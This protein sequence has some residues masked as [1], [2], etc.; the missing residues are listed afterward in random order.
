MP[1]VDIVPDG[2]MRKFR[3]ACD[4]L[5]EGFVRDEQLSE[6]IGKALR[7]TLKKE[8]N[9]PIELLL[10]TLKSAFDEVDGEKAI[11]A[12]GLRQLIDEA[13]S[14]SMSHPRY[15]SIAVDAMKACVEQTEHL[16]FSDA[17]SE[18]FIGEYITRVLTADFYE[19]MPL[20]NYHSGVSTEAIDERLQ[21]VKPYVEHEIA[22]MVK[23]IVRDESAAH[24]RKK[25]KKRG[26]KP[27]FGN[28]DISMPNGDNDGGE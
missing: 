21:R 4:Q 18:A 19:C 12:A 6:A 27:D 24:L 23:Q 9:P 10:A 3:P 14:R 13:A 2:V 5:C 1:D 16:L 7:N 17:M 11:D 20:L 15:T 22:Y 25:R 26:S 28:M 8:G